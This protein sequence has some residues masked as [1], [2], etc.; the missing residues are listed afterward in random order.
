MTAA[1]RLAEL[2]DLEQTLLRLLPTA[3]VEDPAAREV[4]EQIADVLGVTLPYTPPLDEE[5]IP[6][7]LTA[8]GTVAVSA[9]RLRALLAP[10][11]PTRPWR[12]HR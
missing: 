9:A 12:C 3:T 1:E 8:R 11:H 5:P 2:E 4:W 10:T 7:T 6:Y